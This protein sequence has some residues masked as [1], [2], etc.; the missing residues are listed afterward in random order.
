M[1][2]VMGK[3]CVDFHPVGSEEALFLCV[4][5]FPSLW[6]TSKALDTVKY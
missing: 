4:D 5:F 6:M 2:A 3:A 1:Q